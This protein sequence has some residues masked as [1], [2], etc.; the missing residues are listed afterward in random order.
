MTLRIHSSNG[1]VDIQT[2]ADITVKKIIDQLEN[3][4]IVLIE[5]KNK[6]TFIINCLNIVAIEIF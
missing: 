5:T 6:S 1:I 2:A 4:N 3:G